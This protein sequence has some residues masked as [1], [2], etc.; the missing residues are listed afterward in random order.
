VIL[1]ACKYADGQGPAPREWKLYEQWRTW[2]ALPRAGGL[3][4]QPAGLLDRMEM[5]HSAVIAI[6][7]YN[8]AKDKGEFLENNPN[9][10]AL[11]ALYWNAEAENGK[12]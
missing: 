10:T 11:L 1:A 7:E 2:G 8:T 12:K 5:V 4:D 3:L 9:L 6:R